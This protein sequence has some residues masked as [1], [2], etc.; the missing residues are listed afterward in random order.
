M[1]ALHQMI[2]KVLVF[3]VLDAVDQVVEYALPHWPNHNPQA[4][5]N[6]C[7]G[8]DLLLENGN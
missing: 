8:P 5:T 6:G 3:L 4:D 7:D 2:I 1:V